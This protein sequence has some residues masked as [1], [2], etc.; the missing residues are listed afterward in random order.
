MSKPLTI[1][2]LDQLE[3][4]LNRLGK[5]DATVYYNVKMKISEER[6]VVMKLIDGRSIN[7]TDNLNAK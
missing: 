6:R 4:L 1:E 2:D 3:S 5:I 7:P